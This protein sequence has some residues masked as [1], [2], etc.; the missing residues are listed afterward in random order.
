MSDK[1][2]ILIG[3]M[4]K[5][6]AGMESTLIAAEREGLTGERIAGLDIKIDRIQNLLSDLEDTLY[7][8]IE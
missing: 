6:V 2:Q 1:E 8:F 7:N 3:A 5:L 4:R